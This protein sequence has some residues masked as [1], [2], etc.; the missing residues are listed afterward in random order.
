[1]CF[2]REYLKKYQYIINLLFLY[3]SFMIFVLTYRLIGLILISYFVIQLTNRINIFEII[4]YILYYPSYMLSEKYINQN[5]QQFVRG[6]VYGCNNAFKIFQEERIDEKNSFEKKRNFDFKEE[7]IMSNSVLMATSFPIIIFG[8]A[9]L[10]LGLAKLGKAKIN[11]AALMCLLAGLIG[12]TFAFFLYKAGLPHLVGLL[13]TP[14][15][16]APS[17]G[18]SLGPLLLKL[19]SIL[20]LFSM[21]FILV[22]FTGLGREGVELPTTGIFAMIVGLTVMPVGFIIFGVVKMLG[23]VILLYAIAATLLGFAAKTGTGVSAAASVVILVS[24]VNILIGL[25]F[26]LGY[27]VT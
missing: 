15:G 14:D 10:M 21:L 23:L 8:V 4:N 13:A 7:I 11:N 1:M 6:I 25:G 17:L 12:A 5:A 3:Y 24:I 18:D 26:Q 22:G 16:Q 27:I 9:F 20:T 19:A 2:Y